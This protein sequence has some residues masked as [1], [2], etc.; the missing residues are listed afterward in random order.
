MPTLKLTCNPSLSLS[1][2]KVHSLNIV[3]RDLKPENILLEPDGH[4]VLVDFGLA[5]IMTGCAANLHLMV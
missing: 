3:Y 1:L 5:K 4:V 2:I